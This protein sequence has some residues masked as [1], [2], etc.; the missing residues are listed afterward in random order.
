MTEA[1][2]TSPVADDYRTKISEK[3]GASD[4]AIQSI[5]SDLTSAEDDIVESRMEKVP[6]DSAEARWPKP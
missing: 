2:W 4:A 3:V 1:V 5:I 6:R